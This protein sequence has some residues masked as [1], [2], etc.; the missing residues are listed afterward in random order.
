MYAILCRENFKYSQ[1]FP[2]YYRCS[3]ISLK[4]SVIVAD[5]MRLE[6][7][8]RS[9]QVRRVRAGLGLSALFKASLACKFARKLGSGAKS[10]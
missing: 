8:G 2:W 7:L 1:R 9:E 10:D 6:R 5:H 4:I 3:D